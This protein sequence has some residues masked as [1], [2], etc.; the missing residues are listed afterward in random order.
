MSRGSTCAR[1]PAGTGNDRDKS[2]EVTIR[3]LVYSHNLLNSILVDSFLVVH[4]VS[5]KCDQE[6]TII[7]DVFLILPN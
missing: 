4:L 1:V 6:R 2:V 5:L 7:V 3:I